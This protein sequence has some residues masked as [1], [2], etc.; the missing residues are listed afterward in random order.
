MPQ[1]TPTR[2]FSY[3]SA[4]ASND[5]ER[6]AR[7]LQQVPFLDGRLLEDVSLAAG[8][9]TVVNHGL[10]RPPQGWLVTKFSG[11]GAS[12]YPRQ[13]ASTTNTLTLTVTNAAVASLWVF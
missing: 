4:R 6:F 3:E 2:Q 10:G 8:A 5:L 9:S 7:Q 1:Y 13:E 11:A 12:D